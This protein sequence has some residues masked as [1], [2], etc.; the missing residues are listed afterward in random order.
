MK[1]TKNLVQYAK[2]NNY[3]PANLDVRNMKCM[4]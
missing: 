1:Y 4:L 3:V 2:E